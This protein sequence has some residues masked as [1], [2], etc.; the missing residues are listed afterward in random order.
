[1]GAKYHHNNIITFQNNK[2]YALHAYSLYIMRA[3]M[4]MTRPPRDIS[5]YSTNWVKTFDHSARTCIYCIYIYTHTSMILLCKRVMVVEA[6]SL[7]MCLCFHSCSPPSAVM[8]RMSCLTPSATIRSHSPAT[9]TR[10]PS[11]SSTR[12][13]HN[14]ISLC[15][16]LHT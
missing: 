13:T 7:C 12:C 4:T 1:M 2:I 16:C 11:T 6:D 15:N 14:V 8:M 10:P 9:L 3:M 5:L